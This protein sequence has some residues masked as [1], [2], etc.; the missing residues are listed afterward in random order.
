MTPVAFANKYNTAISCTT[1]LKFYCTLNTQ[2]LIFHF[3]L[4]VLLMDGSVFSFVN[5]LSAQRKIIAHFM[6]TGHSQKRNISV[7]QS[8]VKSTL[9][10]TQKKKEKNRF[11]PFTSSQRTLTVA[12]L[13]NK[14]V[15]CQFSTNW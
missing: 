12:P 8:K 3:E 4:M 10:N 7:S 5:A 14:S 15:F 2:P 9:A 13:V 1:S 11:R 6:T